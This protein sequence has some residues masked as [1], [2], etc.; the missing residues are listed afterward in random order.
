MLLGRVDLEIAESAGPEGAALSEAV[1]GL[2]D[3]TSAMR[4][5]VAGV[6]ALVFGAV[7]APAPVASEDGGA[8]RRRRRTS[9][10]SVGQWRGDRL[11]GG[12]DGCGMGGRSNGQGGTCGIGPVVTGRWQSS[13]RCGRDGCGWSCRAKKSSWLRAEAC[14]ELQ[15]STTASCGRRSRSVASCGGRG[16]CGDCS[17]RVATLLRQKWHSALAAKF[18]LVRCWQIGQSRLPVMVKLLPFR[19]WN[20]RSP[21]HLHCRQRRV[22]GVSG[23]QRGT[24]CQHGKVRGGERAL[25]VSRTKRMVFVIERDIAN[26][27]HCWDTSVY[28]RGMLV[29][30]IFG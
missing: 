13:G 8:R 3:V 1:E 4:P 16:C 25:G 22:R 30:Y 17:G 14:E 18:D 21:R 15:R 12:G 23:A 5:H 7:G 2:V 9:T 6:V 19:R 29:S 20:A 11:G 28:R 26:P 10:D 27:I 24:S